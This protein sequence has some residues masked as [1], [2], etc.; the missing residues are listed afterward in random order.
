M[1]AALLVAALGPCAPALAQPRPDQV[2]V[3]YNRDW[4]EDLPGTEAGQDSEEIARYYVARH[5]DPVTGARPYL[6]GLS[7]KHRRGPGTAGPAALHLNGESIEEKSSDNYW[8]WVYTGKGRPLRAGRRGRQKLYL[9]SSHIRCY[10]PAD[11]VDWKSVTLKVAPVGDASKAQVVYAAGKAARAGTVG[12]RRVVARGRRGKGNVRVLSF[13]ARKVG[14]R[15]DVS[16]R[17]SAKDRTG[18][19]VL[20]QEERFFDPADFAFS[21][22]GPDG[23]RDDLHYLEDVEGPVKAFLEDPANA[24]GGTLLKDRILYIVICYG[25][26][27]T[28]RRHFGI[29]Q[30]A[31]PSRRDFGTLISLGQRLE[32]AYY[33]VEA[34]RPPRLGALE[35]RERVGAF[36]AVVPASVY[37]YPFAGR[38]DQPYLHPAAYRDFSAQP[39]LKPPWRPPPHFSPQRRREFPKRFLFVCSRIDAADPRVARRQIDSAVYATRYLTPLIGGKGGRGWSGAE[40]LSATEGKCGAEELKALGFAGAGA[41]THR[42]AYLHRRPGGGYYPGGVD[43]YVISSNGLNR[44]LSHVRRALRAGVTVTGGAARAYRGCPHTTTHAWWDGR[45]FYHFLFRGFSLGE[46]W[47]LSRYKIG[48]VTCFFGDPLYRPDLRRTRPDATPPRVARPEDISLAVAPAGGEYYAVL[49][50]EL[51]TTP[52]NPELVRAEVRYWPKDHRDGA[53]TSVQPEFRLRPRV[54]L[55]G[56]KP[57]T[58]YAYRLRL[59]DPYE[60]TFDSQE[61]FGRLT[62]RTAGPLPPWKPNLTA[63]NPAV[64]SLS[65]FER[66]RR[67]L[68][69]EAGQIELTWEAGTAKNYDLLRCGDLRLRQVG[70]VVRLEVGGGPLARRNYRFKPGRTYRLEVRYRKSPVTREVWL[71][72]ADGS[73][74]LLAADNRSVWRD[75]RLGG[76][77]VLARSAQAGFVRRL[78]LYGDCRVSGITGDRA[79]TDFDAAA[80]DRA[81]GYKAGDSKD[82]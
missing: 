76:S 25:L 57:Q 39:G 69:P 13:D 65:D 23:I 9:L 45:V 29:A 35:L 46:A 27:K 61:A 2:L 28:V 73:R 63:G 68:R 54:I 47:L 56:L 36:G 19:I 78:A 71:I 42:S 48:W 22:T 12:V 33:D 44:N 5:T 53:A 75:V 37:W 17:L 20:D 26:P 80:F 59:I 7:C 55:A 81:D 30:G 58:T 16:V 4:T 62:F 34:V 40:A 21:R 51:H 66:A 18:K 24:V 10:V 15:G 1:V 8:G 6:L 72:A 52:A 49:T 79:G 32:M 50:A 74:H 14:F 70:G 64:V 82:R 31:I 41:S 43:W 77:L 3:L 60:N 11:E 67:P 38:R